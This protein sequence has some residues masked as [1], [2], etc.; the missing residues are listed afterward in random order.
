MELSFPYRFGKH[1]LWKCPDLV[2]FLGDN[3]LAVVLFKFCVSSE[4][5][6]GNLYLHYDNLH[7]LFLESQPFYLDIQSFWLEFSRESLLMIY[8][9]KIYEILSGNTDGLYH[10]RPPPESCPYPFLKNYISSTFQLVVNSSNFNIIILVYIW[11]SILLCFWWSIF[12]I[13]LPWMTSSFKYLC[14]LLQMSNLLS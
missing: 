10:D 13:P 2:G 8:F 6:F 3:R 9:W 7:L 11:I 5:H 1:F 4:I 12:I 14:C